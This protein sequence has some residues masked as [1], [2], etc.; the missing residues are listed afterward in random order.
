MKSFN[1]KKIGPWVGVLFILLFVILA[2]KLILVMT[3]DA[4]EIKS[5]AFAQLRRESL[6]PARRGDILDRNGN[7]LASSISSFQVE[8]DLATMQRIA[9]KK[10]EITDLTAEEEEKV[11]ARFLCPFLCACKEREEKTPSISYFLPT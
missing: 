4:G 10:E 8:A 9:L 2:I 7:L 1:Q 5:K 11:L 3:Y 6:L